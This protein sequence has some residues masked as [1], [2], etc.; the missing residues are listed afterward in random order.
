MLPDGSLFFLSTTDTDSGSYYCAVLSVG[1]KYNSDTAVLTVAEHDEDYQKLPELDEISIK[2]LSDSVLVEWEYFPKAESYIVQ[3]MIR[4]AKK[5]TKNITVEKDMN[6]VKLENILPNTEYLIRVS[7]VNMEGDISA[8]YKPQHLTLSDYSSVS[9]EDN[10][11]PVLWVVSLTVVVIIT[12]LTILAVAVMIIKIKTFKH[13]NT[14]TDTERQKQRQFFSTKILSQVES[15]WNFYVKKKVK[16][17]KMSPD[18]LLRYHIN[19]DYDYSDTD[20]YL[21]NSDTSSNYFN[22]DSSSTSNHYACTVVNPDI[23]HYNN[24]C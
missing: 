1:M 24:H 16:M 8:T 5:A 10:F 6:A 14:D 22:S 11:H 7:A 3:I 2:V 21:F 4:E 23:F 15:P 17:K 20:Q 18:R 9:H 13:V 12:I 19:S